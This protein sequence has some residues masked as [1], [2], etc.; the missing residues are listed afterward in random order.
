M[1][2]LSRGKKFFFSALL[3]IFAL[4]ALEFFLRFLPEP[5]RSQSYRLVY[6]PEL[7]FPKFYLKDA[8]LFWRLR[9][10][11]TI[12]SD[13][14]VAGVYRINSAGFRDREFSE[15]PTP[16][17]CRVLCLGNSVTFG[18]R[19]AQEESYPQVLQKMAEDY[20]VYNC[21]QTG[22][23]T[24]Q[25][26]R[27]L[28]Q[29]LRK[30]RPEAVTI[31]YIWNDLLP[32]AN[33]I[34]DSRQTMPPQIV[35]KVQ[36]FLAHLA[37]YRWGRY[38]TLKLFS[39][40]PKVSELARVSLEEYHANLQAMVDSCLLHAVRPVLILPPAPRP[41]LLGSGQERYGR[42]FY[43]SFQKYAVE[44]KRVALANHVPL[45]DADSALADERSIWEELPDD[46]VHPNGTGQKQIAHLLASVLV[47]PPKRT[48]VQN[49]VARA[50]RLNWP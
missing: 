48:P 32:A 9:P 33:G 4:A 45:V 17:K 31:A 34:A 1:E 25:G 49:K 37:L 23:T 28:A 30:Y 38:L 19:A 26:K 21:G 36:N 20:E 24:F 46:F 29:L 43:Q 40:P 44:M 2:N 47:N 50:I 13:F 15:K 10:N 7:D 22:Y 8:K 6:N 18:W 14:A 41:E 27:L 42:F 5:P 16:G 11:Q 35:L 12:K 3:F 39:F